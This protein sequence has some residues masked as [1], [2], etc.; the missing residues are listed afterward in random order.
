LCIAWKDG[1]TSWERL[2]ELKESNPVEVS[3]YAVANNLLDAPAFVWWVPYLLKKRSRI[4]ADVTKHYHK[5]THKFRIKFPI[6]WDDC[7]RLDKENDNTLCQDAV[8]KDMKNF[9]I[10]F[11]ILNGDESAPPSLPRDLLSHDI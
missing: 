3:E 2:D 6:S 11:K 8:R 7:V 10:A 4:I 1:T 9:R 5:C